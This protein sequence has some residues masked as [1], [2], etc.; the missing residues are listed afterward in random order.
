M[1]LDDTTRSSRRTR[2][3]TNLQL[4][5]SKERF[6]FGTSWVDN[7]RMCAGYVAMYAVREYGAGMHEMVTGIE[8]DDRTKY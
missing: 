2:R 5:L 6:G 4:L 8:H 1:I 3:R 7:E